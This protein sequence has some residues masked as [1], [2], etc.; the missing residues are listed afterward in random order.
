MDIEVELASHG[1]QIK[2]LFHRVDNIETEQKTI[3]DLVRTVDRLAVATEAMAK[4]Q[5][6]QGK[7]LKTLEEKPVA[8]MDFVKRQIIS[9]IISVVVGGIFGA[10]LALILK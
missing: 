10:F 7:R 5:A 4:E 6:E 9:V 3:R 8:A 2:T 1:E